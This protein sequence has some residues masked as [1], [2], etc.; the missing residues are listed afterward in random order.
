[1]YVAGRDVFTIADVTGTEQSSR[2]AVPTP[3]LPQQE[4]KNIAVSGNCHLATAV[5][6][7]AFSDLVCPGQQYMLPTAAF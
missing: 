6:M 5:Q 4:K 3:P 1:M 2:W 7:P